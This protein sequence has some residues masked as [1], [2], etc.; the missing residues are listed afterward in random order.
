MSTVEPFA[1]KPVSEMVRDYRRRGG[2]TQR[3]VADRAG[4]SVGGLRDLEQ[5]RIA[6]PRGGTLKRL[7]AALELSAAEVAELIRL[8]QQGPLLA[9]DF[10]VQ[11]LGPLQVQAAGAELRL[12]STRQ[13]TMLAMLALSPTTPVSR[14]RLIDAMWGSSPPP[15]AEELV[16]TY[17]SRLRQR[18]KQVDPS[19]RVGPLLA[20]DGGYR[21]LLEDDQ[22]DLC[23]FR[24]LVAAA[25]KNARD[26]QWDLAF[27]NY[28]QAALL[29]RDEP[30][31]D[32]PGMQSQ[33]SVVALGRERWR[34]LKEYADVAAELGRQEE[35]LPLL[36]A[37]AEADPLNEGL[38]VRLMTALASTGQQVAALDAFTHVR[39]R[40]A[41]DLGVDPGPELQRTHQ[42]VLRGDIVEAV[43]AGPLHRSQVRR[44]A[45][46][47]A[48]MRGFAGRHDELETLDALLQDL[49]H[50]AA[51]PTILALVGTV[52]VGKSA[53][54]VQW[55]RSVADR[56]PDG[57]LYVDLGGYR[58]EAPADPNHV[59]GDLLVTLGVTPA[60]LPPDVRDRAL[61]YRDLLRGRRVMVLLDNASD[62][63]QV[64]PL[65]PGTHT[66][67]ALVTSTDD[68]S[69]LVLH[70]NAYTLFVDALSSGDA[71]QLLVNR[72][73][74]PRVDAEPSAT[75][76]IVESCARLP[77]ALAAIAARASTHPS[78]PLSA[79]ADQLRD[80]GDCLGVLDRGDASTS[81][82]G[83]FTACYG[84]LTPAAAQLF[85]LL[86]TQACQSLSVVAAAEL[87]A[88]TVERVR[89][90]LEELERHH[91]I[92]E[93]WPGTYSWHRLLHA[94]ATELGSAT[95][96]SDALLHPA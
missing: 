10:Y 18:L 43:P 49:E 50:D 92:R 22:I 28:Q 40:L 7:G 5:R 57:Q 1:L 89:P 60:S 25:R 87:V 6:Q 76:D 45:M 35:L 11:L 37:L 31:A 83:A 82:R 8:S 53:L 14:E 47:P 34:A 73:G 2:W 81:L 85:R 94:F 23:A 16:Q 38:H 51:A 63:A 95:A 93:T 4:M 32:L 78:F 42:R 36:Q 21:L 39:R 67:L 79:F 12:G 56:F 52:G 90:L 26:G 74:G 61:L 59:L 46:L 91:V 54:A 64:Q 3:E 66:S 69:G 19:D 65:L 24:N 27:T 62:D 84:R 71:R 13:R 30:L 41:E 58:A 75:S 88:S 55:T 20:V 96:D 29:W 48:A 68:L 33:P 86:G 77:L 15:S 17:V 72:L 44:P 80:A 9:R 70:H